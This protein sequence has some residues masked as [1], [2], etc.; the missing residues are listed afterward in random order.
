MPRTTRALG[1]ENCLAHYAPSKAKAVSLKFIETA[2]ALPNDPFPTEKKPLGKARL[3]SFSGDF[4]SAFSL[5]FAALP[6]FCSLVICS[7]RVSFIIL[8]FL[9]TFQIPIPECAKSL[10]ERFTFF[11]QEEK[12]PLR[13]RFN[14]LIS[15]CHSLDLGKYSLR[16][17][18]PFLFSSF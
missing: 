3:F 13:T 15:P 8:P 9:Y 1:R 17:A 11:S 12:T 10:L 5:L 18:I 7:F 4:Y 16:C 6:L 2:F 14:R